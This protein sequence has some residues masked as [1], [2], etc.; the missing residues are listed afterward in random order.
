MGSLP[1]LE[2]W[3]LVTARFVESA[4]SGEGAKRYGGRWNRKGIPI[5][6]TAGSLSLAML[7]MLVQDQPLRARYMAIPAR[8]PMELAIERV[9]IPQLP[10]NWRDLSALESLRIIGNEWAARCSS[11]VLAVPSAVIPQEVNCLL[12]PRHSQFAE[13]AIGQPQELV[14]DLRFLKQKLMRDSPR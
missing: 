4:F 2:V 1:D 5:V 12:N 10:P 9:D 14:T 11:A 7:E 13:I 8:I 6:Y 3:R